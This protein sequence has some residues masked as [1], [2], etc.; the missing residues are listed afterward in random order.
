MFEG[1]RVSVVVP[2]RNEVDWIGGTVRSIPSF[3]DHVVVVDDASEDATSKVALGARPDVEIVSHAARRGVGAAIVTGYARAL[4][5]GA[6]AAVV[7]AGDGQMC[8]DDLPSLLAPL[9][10]GEADYAKGDRMKHPDVETVMPRSRY[11]AGRVLS[12]LTGAAVG[13]PELSDSQSGYTAISRRALLALDLD[14]VWTGYGYPND[15]LGRVVVAG[16]TA[17]DVP[18]RP[19]YRGEK[20]GLRPYHL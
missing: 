5:R 11:L 8:P 20:S 10:R 9:V 14:A 17:V 13:L 3:V 19:V 16:F 2:A 18:V 15:L 7:M 4:A 12:R 1:L 6:D